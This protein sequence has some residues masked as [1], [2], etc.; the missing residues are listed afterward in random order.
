MKQV[1][2]TDVLNRHLFTICLNILAKYS[3]YIFRTNSYKYV[4]T[5]W[6]VM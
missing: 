3:I 6:Y 4:F 5:I 2:N 1:A